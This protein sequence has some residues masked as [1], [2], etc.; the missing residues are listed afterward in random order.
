MHP[1]VT[2]SL[3]LDEF[4]YMFQDLGEISCIRAATGK[5]LWK[6]KTKFKFYASPIWIGGNIYCVTRAGEVVVIK[7][8]CE[9]YEL[10][11]VNPLGEMSHS[12]PAVASEQMY[13]KTFSHLISIGGK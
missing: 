2:T 6:E 5:R 1:Y 12:T 11:A 3:A 9:N 4:I 10:L 7:G 13:L 8:T